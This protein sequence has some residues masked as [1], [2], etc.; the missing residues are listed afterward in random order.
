MVETLIRAF[1][2]LFNRKAEAAIEAPQATIEHQAAEITTLQ[3]KHDQWVDAANG[4]LK[5]NDELRAEVEQLR[6]AQGESVNKWICIKCHHESYGDS[7]ADCGCTFDFHDH[8]APEQVE[9]L[10][11]EIERLEKDSASWEMLCGELSPKLTL[12]MEQ[13][14]RQAALLKQLEKDAERYRYLRSQAVYEG[15]SD[16]TIEV[17]GRYATIEEAIDAAIEEYER[18]SS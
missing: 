1:T 3:H 5:T 4:L 18:A 9:Q 16:W 7:P 12:A 10:K 14:T 17:W 2:W 8:P 13:L 11:A 6:K 15:S